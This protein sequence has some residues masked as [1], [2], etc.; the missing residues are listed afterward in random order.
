MNLPLAASSVEKQ[1]SPKPWV[2]PKRGL[3]VYYGCPQMPGLSH[4]F[5]PRVLLGEN[6][7]LYFDGV[8]EQ[9]RRSAYCFGYVVQGG[10]SPAET[11][12]YPYLDA[13]RAYTECT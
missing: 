9:Q 2:L 1:S 7:V 3:T 12:F 10:F 6:R 11:G 5:L 13:P 8:S 4:Y